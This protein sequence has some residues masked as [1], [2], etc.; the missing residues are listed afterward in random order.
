V[1]DIFRKDERRGTRV[2]IESVGIVGGGAWGTALAQ[3]IRQAGRE[4][5]LWAREGDVVA[6]INERHVNETFLPG[7]RLDAGV[8]ATSKL[9]RRRRAMLCCWSRPHN[10][11]AP[12]PGTCGRPCARRNPL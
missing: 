1:L 2:N 11:C 4:V 9:A 5:V 10:M 8:R 12:W 6:S 3:T 7:V